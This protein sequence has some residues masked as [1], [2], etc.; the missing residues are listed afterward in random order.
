[1]EKRKPKLSFVIPCYYSELTIESVVEDIKAAFDGK[2][3]D[4]EVVL[5][6]DGSKDNTFSVI[7]GLAKKYENVSAYNLSKNFGQDA[8]LMAGYSKT[9]GDYIISLDDDGQNPPA[10]AF[11]LIE[12]LEEG[13]D[14]VFGKYHVKKH[15]WFKNFG[16]KLND[17]MAD[18]LIQ[19]PK[20][21]YLCSYFI[22]N[23]FV[24]EQMQNYKNAFPYIWG[25]ILRSTDRITNVYVDHK[26]REIGT[27]TFTF[28]KLVG[29]WLNGFTAFSIKPLRVASV[30]GM[31]TALT[32]FLFGTYVVC[33]QF[34]NPDPEVGWASL[35][36][37]M[38]FLGGVVLLML[39]LLG[40]YIGRTYISIN[41]APQFIIR[42]GEEGEEDD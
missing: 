12:K 17:L 27:T 19:K 20:E 11:K 16:S 18:A 29:L 22:M 3:Y 5:V 1:M 42:P 36:A 21:L 10:E 6:N 39:G 23:R 28:A 2:G 30:L 34:I 25:L 38:V 41:N 40:E 31:L 8:A 26:A 33:K 13:Y 15:S 14:V 4:Y 32:G 24:L 37:V 7:R 9:S 35:M